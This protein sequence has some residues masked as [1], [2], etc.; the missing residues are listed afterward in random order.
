LTFDSD[1]YYL[2]VYECEWKQYAYYRVDRMQAVSVLPEERELPEAAFDLMKEL[3][4]VFRMY[5]GK[6]ADMCVEFCNEL[7]GP[8]MDKFGQEIIMVPKGEDRFEVH[9]KA[10]ISPPFLSWLVGFG[11]KAKIISPPWVIDEM[12]ALMADV[13]SQYE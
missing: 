2:V 12:E 11:N 10:A 5:G 8:L 6:R 3:R 4:P 9:F 13:A 7:A 1:N